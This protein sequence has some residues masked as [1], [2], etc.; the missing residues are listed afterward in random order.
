MFCRSAAR[1][2]RPARDRTPPCIPP[3]RRDR[4][5]GFRMAIPRDGAGASAAALARGR[6]CTTGAAPRRR[7]R[8]WRDFPG[9]GHGAGAGDRAMAAPAPSP[10]PGDGGPCADASTINADPRALLPTAFLPPP[11]QWKVVRAVD[12][13]PQILPDPCPARRRL[14]PPCARLHR[15][16][17]ALARTAHSDL[18]IRP[19]TSPH[20]RP[21]MDLARC[22]GH[23]RCDLRRALTSYATLPILL[24][25]VVV[26]EGRHRH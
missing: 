6:A 13:Q 5:P 25:V 3:S 14:H 1:T 7:G 2:P 19:Q 23:A 12:P 24:A 22:P 4:R 21:R 18:P 20:A 9:P 15:A 26:G 17:S 8:G 16:S 10:I 11:P